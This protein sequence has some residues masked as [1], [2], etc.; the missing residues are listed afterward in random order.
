L[1]AFPEKED[2]TVTKLLLIL[3]IAS[4]PALAQSVFDGTWRLN[5]SD[6]QVNVTERF[7]LKDGLFSCA[8]CDPPIKDLS[9]DGQPHK[10]ARSPYYDSVTVHVIDDRTVEYTSTKNG[11]TVENSK[12]TVSKNNK[13]ATRDE[14]FTSQSGQQNHERDLWKRTADGPPGA[15]KISGTWQPVKIEDASDSLRDVTFKATENGLLWH[16]GQ[17]DSYEARFDGKDYP[18]KGD[19][20]TTSVSLR[21]IDNNTFEESDK[22]DGKTL[23][24]WRMTVDP[25]GK[26]MKIAIRDKLHNT[27][28]SFTATKQ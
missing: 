21:K 19:P 13:E 12:I 18:Y 5:I 14:T 26:T 1:F 20:G 8:A 23:Y 25:D 3:V 9:T 27:T 15:H 17:G 4:I 16:D 7:L 10:V 11:K 24:I 22:R 6:A 28:L 2:R